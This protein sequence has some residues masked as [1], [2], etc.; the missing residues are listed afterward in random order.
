MTEKRRR[1]ARGKGERLEQ[2]IVDA[3]VRLIDGVDQLLPITLRGVAREAGISAPSIYDHF[4]DVQS[5][6]DAVLARSFAELDA[7][8]GAAVDAAASPSDALVAGCFAY[9]RYGWEHRAR[10]RFMFGAGGFA[11]RAIVTFQRIAQSLQACIDGGVSS[12]KDART[13]ALLVWIGMHGM[14]TL[15]KP[16]RG[17][18]RKLGPLDRA[19]LVEILA[20]RLGGLTTRRVTGSP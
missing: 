8:V 11:P 1:N 10:F 12:S 7:A 5:I 14:A 15:E 2:E 17:R 13:D 9:V 16:A 19:E 3:A 18:L 20:R 4:A 6:T